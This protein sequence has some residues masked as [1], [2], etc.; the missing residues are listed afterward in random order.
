MTLV[1]GDDVIGLCGL[2]SAEISC[3]PG[4]KKRVPRRPAER[5]HPDCGTWRAPPRFRTAETQVSP[6]RAW[7][8]IP[9][10]QERIPTHTEI[11]H[12]GGRD[13]HYWAPPA[14]NRTGSFP[15]YGSHLGC[16]TAGLGL[17][18]ALRRR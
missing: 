2:R 6:A 16:L 3:R 9:R 17:P 13:A 4:R 12:D 10:G 5:A 1:A 8:R 11:S 15:A 14:Q 18:Y 7:P